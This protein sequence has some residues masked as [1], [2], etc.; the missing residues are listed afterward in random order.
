MDV[1]CTPCQIN[2]S[3]TRYSVFGRVGLCVGKII[4][5]RLIY[6]YI[7]LRIDGHTLLNLWLNW[8]EIHTNGARLLC[9]PSF[10]NMRHVNVAYSVLGH[11]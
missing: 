8:E 6:R 3:I 5:K 7:T 4:G 10:V 2:A 9:V 1:T 11:S